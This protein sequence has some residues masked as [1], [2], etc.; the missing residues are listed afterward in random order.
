MYKLAPKNDK[1][2]AESMLPLTNPIYWCDRGG[3]YFAIKAYALR[4]RCRSSRSRPIAKKVSG[5]RS[6]IH[7]WR[8]I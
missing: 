4:D 5:W 3:K 6:T 2:I 1:F 8:A 7:F